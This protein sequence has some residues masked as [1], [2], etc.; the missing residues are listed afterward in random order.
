M[1]LF[2]ACGSKQG[3]EG[4]NPSGS[5]A[6]GVVFM[7][8]KAKLVLADALSSTGFKADFF[9]LL[10]VPSDRALGDFALP[11]FKLSSIAGKA[12][13]VVALKL[14]SR[15]VLP[16]LFRSCEAKGPYLNFFLNEQAFAGYFFPVL[17]S[18]GTDYGK[19]EKGKAKVIVEYCQANP[20]K[21]FHIGH[22]RNICLG[23]AIAKIMEYFG[24]NVFR[25]D[26]CGDVGTHV[27]KVLYAYQNIP[28]EPEPFSLS[29]KEKWLNKLYYLGDQASSNN[30]ALQEKLREMVVL[31]EK[32]DPYLKADWHYLRSISFDCFNQIFEQLGT[33]F[34]RIICESEVE[35]DGI[36]LALEL[37]KNGFAR[38]DQGALIVDLKK[39]GLGIFLILKNDGSALYSTKDLALAR[40]KK[41]EIGAVISYNL[42]GSEQSFYFKQLI[43]TIELLNKM[44]PE[45]CE[46]VHLPYELVNI[47]GEKM[48]SRLGNV[49]TY[50]E[51]FGAIFS[52][53]LEETKARHPDWDDRKCFAIA[54]KIS[55]SAL[56]FGMIYQE[57]NRVLSFNWEK[58]VKFEG[59]TGPFVLYS[60]ARALSILRK[61]PFSKLPENFLFETQA[62]LDLVVL[63]GKFELVALQAYEAKAPNKIAQ[64][65]LDLSRAFNA[66]YRDSPVI[67]SEGEKLNSRLALV[68]ASAIVFELSCGLL[69]I[70]LPEEM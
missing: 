25:I 4:S 46:T 64:Y 42:V 26:Y 52:K 44:K 67:S 16:E 8:L 29:E 58:A 14:K 65:L 21:A 51:L 60:Y 1:I 38:R 47:E 32:G 70:S 35:K 17:F 27:S 37:E 13:H 69:N 28:H 19:V 33:K 31:L 24:N 54:K 12:P 6:G 53:T 41:K 68:K 40:L 11:C 22:T 45:F 20:M 55:L 30:P 48:S 57:R 10:E 62:E 49:I 66:F 50:S 56:K 9:R 5:D 3:V 43:K 23:E 15:V 61:K 18:K 39:Y 2:F 59:E 7:F 34:D 36:A 63:L